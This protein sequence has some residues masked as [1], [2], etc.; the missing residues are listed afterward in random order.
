MT[1][2]TNR[3]MG[4][5]WG[6]YYD[7]EQMVVVE[8]DLGEEFMILSLAVELR[9]S[10]DVWKCKMEPGRSVYSIK[11]VETSCSPCEEIV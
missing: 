9:I 2:G 3:S 5:F 11:R 8:G 4:L 10:S 6:R 7:E 1:L